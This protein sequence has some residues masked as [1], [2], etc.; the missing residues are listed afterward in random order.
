[1]ALLYGL[2]ALIAIWFVAKLFAGT[3]PALLAKYMKTLG[4]WASM[5]LAAFLFMRGR[6]DMAMLV[7]GFGAW[8]L[9][10]AYHHP[11]SQWTQNWRKSPGQNSRVASKMIEMELDHDSGL[12]RGKV[13][14]GAYAG[15]M[16]DSMER[17]ELLTLIT[18]LQAAGDEDGIRLLDAYL[19]RRFAGGGA[20]AQPDDDAGR[21]RAGKP[22]TMS[23]KEAYDILG[24]QPGASEEAVRNAHRSLIKRLHPDAGGSSALAARVN[25]AKDVLLKGHR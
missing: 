20:N 5:G 24:L 7:G 1:M 2:A 6:I 11:L 9:G 14:G 12:M 16:L 22:G 23:E 3:N 18:E 17:T 8:L 19:D 15:R 21:G 25:E 10:W 4:G 13:T